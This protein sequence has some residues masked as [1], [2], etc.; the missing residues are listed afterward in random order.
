MINDIYNG[1]DTLQ[2]PITSK[3]V[4]ASVRST[5]QESLKTS[6]TN[7]QTV[8]DYEMRQVVRASLQADITNPNLYKANALGLINPASVVW[9]LV[10]YSF[11]VDWF[12]PVGGFLSSFTWDVGLKILRPQRTLFCEVTNSYRL[13]PKISGIPYGEAKVYGATVRRTTDFPLP[14][15]AVRP[16]NGFSPVRGATA[17]AL[18]INLLR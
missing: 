2:S 17:C 8:S 12:V 13:F 1:V 6:N 9:E 11:V 7:Y 14:K 16:F 4:R 18:L 5:R 15:L 3:N 10:P